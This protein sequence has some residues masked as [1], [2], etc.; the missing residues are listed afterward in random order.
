[1][2]STPRSPRPEPWKPPPSLRTAGSPTNPTN[3]LPKPRRKR[4]PLSNSQRR[5]R[6]R[7]P[8]PRKALPPPRELS[9]RWR[10]RANGRPLGRSLQ[11][12]DQRRN[13]QRRRDRKSVV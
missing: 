2:G 1:S 5:R 7:N 6:H 9:P 10:K 13:R 12:K 8:L 4:S 3:R 11:R